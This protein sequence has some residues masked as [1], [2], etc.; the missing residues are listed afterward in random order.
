MKTPLKSNQINVHI[1]QYFV[2]VYRIIKLLNAKTNGPMYHCEDKVQ[3]EEMPPNGFRAI[4]ATSGNSTAC[5]LFADEASRNSAYIFLRSALGTDGSGIHKAKESVRFAARKLM[6][7]IKKS[8]ETFYDENIPFVALNASSDVT[9]GEV[10]LD[11]VENG[12][13]TIS[14]DTIKTVTSNQKNIITTVEQMNNVITTAQIMLEQ[15]NIKEGTVNGDYVV[16]V[17]NSGDEIPPYRVFA[18]KNSIGAAQAWNA[19]QGF[20]YRVRAQQKYLLIVLNADWF[21]KNTFDSKTVVLTTKQNVN[22]LEPDANTNGKAKDTLSVANAVVVRNDKYSTTV[23]NKI[24][25]LNVGEKITEEVFVSAS[26]SLEKRTLLMK[27]I[28][29]SLKSERMVGCNAPLEKEP[30]ASYQ[31]PPNMVAVDK[32]FEIYRFKDEVCA[33]KAEDSASAI[34]P[35]GRFKRMNNALFYIFSKETFAL[36]TEENLHGIIEGKRYDMMLKLKQV[37]IV[38]EKQSIPV[39]MKIKP[40]IDATVLDNFTDSTENRSS[41]MKQ[42]RRVLAN[43]NMT[44]TTSSFKWCPTASYIYL[45]IQTVI[46]RPYELYRFSDEAKAKQA[47]LVLLQKI[48]TL[49]IK[50]VEA[51]LFFIFCKDTEFDSFSTKDLQDL[52]CGIA[53]RSVLLRMQNTGSTTNTIQSVDSTSRAVRSSEN[54]QH[55]HENGQLKEVFCADVKKDYETVFSK[56]PAKIGS[57]FISR[58]LQEICAE[59]KIQLSHVTVSGDSGEQFVSVQ[60]V[61]PAIITNELTAK[62]RKYGIE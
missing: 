28:R 33:K 3:Y 25:V 14:G 50:R 62:L 43:E 22:Y 26:E 24:A 16:D 38:K 53:Y 40:E 42:V 32:P 4:N 12:S 15:K 6:I 11:T 31:Y 34:L 17:Y 1:A 55:E 48:P 59:Q 52:L 39:H 35:A 29:V 60:P 56:T 30:T 44:G 45:A 5:L 13:T 18:F 37:S 41:V 46:K 20:K 19:L 9:V 21:T 27:K 8:E 23:Q 61:L 10:H 2:S 36:F 7:P 51:G 47:E 57:A 49:L 54:L 58:L